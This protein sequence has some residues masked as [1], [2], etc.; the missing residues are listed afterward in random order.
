MTHQVQEFRDDLEGIRDNANDQVYNLKSLLN[1]DAA[2]KESLENR[3]VYLEHDCY[4]ET[5]ELAVSLVV[6]HI[7]SYYVPLYLPNM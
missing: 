6:K 2:K 3:V 7:L 5:E 1:F 4:E